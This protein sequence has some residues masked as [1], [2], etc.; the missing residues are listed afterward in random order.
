MNLTWKTGVEKEINDL[1]LQLE[2]VENQHK[3]KRR[4]HVDDHWNNIL[5][6]VAHRNFLE[7]TL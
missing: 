6:H 1:D 7:L 3:W 2:M 4:I 5:V